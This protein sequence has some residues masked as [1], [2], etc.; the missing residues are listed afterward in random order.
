MPNQ[1]SSKEC[2][3]LIR[4]G[5]I[6]MT[7]SGRTWCMVL[8]EPAAQNA[9]PAHM[10]SEISC[11]EETRTGAD[12]AGILGRAFNPGVC[13]WPAW[14]ALPCGHGLILAD[15]RREWVLGDHGR[16]AASV[17]GAAAACPQGHVPAVPDNAAVCLARRR[18]GRRGAAHR[19]AMK[20]GGRWPGWRSDA[21]AAGFLVSAVAARWWRSPSPSATASG[22]PDR[23]LCP[24]LVR[25]M[26]VIMGS[27]E[28]T[29]AYCDGLR[30][31]PERVADTSSAASSRRSER[32]N[33]CATTGWEGLDAE[34]E[35]GAGTAPP[36]RAG[37]FAD[38]LLRQAVPTRTRFRIT[39]LTCWYYD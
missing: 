13:G 18:V 29:T 32:I 17:P 20:A 5:A 2:I 23:L 7:G 28:H 25:Y 31:R 37:G 36:G 27:A 21:G 11:L 3:Y 1:T 12:S 22:A 16:R 35:P 10:Y 14:L 24:D 33:A 26:S 4:L 38:R 34:R 39:G 8:P 6:P 30:C 9:D 15:S 19:A